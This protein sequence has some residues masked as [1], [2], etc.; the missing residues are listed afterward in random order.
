MTTYLFQAGN[1][2]EVVIQFDRYI[3]FSEVIKYLSDQKY[4]DDHVEECGFKLRRI[5][6]FVRVRNNASDHKC[7]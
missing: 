7:S 6:E 3:T 4:I 1:G 5:R 2:H